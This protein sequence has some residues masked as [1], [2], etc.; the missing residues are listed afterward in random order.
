[1]KRAARENA[2][3]KLRVAFLLTPRFTLT[4][5]AGFVDALRLAA[6]EGDRSRQSL[7]RWAVLDAIDGPV[8]SS[9]GAA[10]APNAPL[11]SARDYDYVV[12][13]GGLL[14]GGQ[15]VPARLTAFLREAAAAGVKLVGLCTGSFVLAR[16]GLLDGHVACVSWFHHEE[17]ATEFPECRIVS[18]QMFVVDRDR[19]TCAGGTSVVHLAAHI[20]ER[21]LGRTSAVKALRIMIEEQPLPSRTLQPEQ[22]LSVRSTDTV[23]HKAMLLLEQQ[24]HAS[25]TIEALCEPLGIGRRQLERRFRQDVGLSPAEYR[26]QLRLERARWLLQNTDLDV[27]EVSLECGFQDSASFA[28]VV[29]KALGL[30]PREVR[31]AARADR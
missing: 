14:H 4:A 6:D 9:C 2:E 8:A 15:R 1:M 26:Q 18:N 11:G 20:I 5:F 23:V 22:V 13:V 17:F 31:Q 30:S 16:A 12:V 3:P 10:V 19:L 28:R 29:R 24:L 25:A 7:A 27:T 21:T